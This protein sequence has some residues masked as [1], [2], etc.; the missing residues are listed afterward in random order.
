MPWRRGLTYQGGKYLYHVCL[1][2]QTNFGFRDLVC[3]SVV[4]D[5]DPF[6]RLC[7]HTSDKYRHNPR[8]YWDTTVYALA[9]RLQ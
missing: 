2:L 7:L 8:F 1:V 5:I 9:L 4:G 3:C 6:Q